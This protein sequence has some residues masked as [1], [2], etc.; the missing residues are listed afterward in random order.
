VRYP[1]AS[2]LLRSRYPLAILAGLL[3]AASLPKIGVAGL[4]WIAPALMLVAALGKRGWE[5]F[6][7]GYVA[8]LAYWLASLYWLLLIPYR[9]HSIPVGPAAGWLA[10]SAY[11][12]LF[13]ATWVWLVAAVQSPRSTVRSPEPG[14]CSASLVAGGI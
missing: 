6:R 2:S 10:L 13:P 9:W 5:S 7:I 11:M 8:G 14:R 1:N 12:A 4:A 3:L